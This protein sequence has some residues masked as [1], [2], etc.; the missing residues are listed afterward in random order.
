MFYSF[1]RARIFGLTLLVV[2]SLWLFFE[3][4]SHVPRESTTVQRKENKLIFTFSPQPLHPPP[5]LHTRLKLV[6]QQVTSLE[7]ENGQKLSKKFEE[8]EMYKKTETS[9]K[10][11]KGNKQI[12]GRVYNFD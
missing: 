5:F 4:F 6:S 9:T 7:N 10:Y 1:C 3:V 12:A 8:R 11:N 2:Q